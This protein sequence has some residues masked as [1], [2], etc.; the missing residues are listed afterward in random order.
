M[1]APT[2]DRLFTYLDELIGSKVTEE[3]KHP[4]FEWEYLVTESFRAFKTTSN[5]V[6]SRM[7]KLLEDDRLAKVQISAGGYVHTDVKELETSLF[8]AY[9]QYH[10]PYSY[11]SENYGYITHE[12]AK[13]HDNVWRSGIRYL[14]TTRDRYDELI[15]DLLDAKRA[16]DKAD[17]EERKAKRQ[18]INDALDNIAPDA[19]E[20]LDRFRDLG[21]NAEADVRLRSFV[22]DDDEEEG[23]VSA[24]FNLYGTKA[25]A[26]FI[27]VLRRGL[28]DVPRE[29]SPVDD[30]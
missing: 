5:A 21:R 23:G 29:T 6:R 16:K 24:T 3:N 17:K 19:R 25:L 27:D 13:G 18:K 4:V 2:P 10:Q 20:L 26:V 8:Y 30:A 12:R 1:P 9:F 15:T 11:A 28:P 7:D 22:F 14:F